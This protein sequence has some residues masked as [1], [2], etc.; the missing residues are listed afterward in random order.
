MFWDLT[1]FEIDPGDCEK[2]QIRVDAHI[3]LEADV[4]GF[5]EDEDLDHSASEIF[6]N[7]I[8]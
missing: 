1:P 2:P 8:W 7:I 4:S 3:K 5:G 6:R